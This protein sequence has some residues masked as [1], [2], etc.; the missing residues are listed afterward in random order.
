MNYKVIDGAAAENQKARNEL[1]AVSEMRGVYP[2]VFLMDPSTDTT[3]FIGTFETIESLI[4]DNDLP[5]AIVEE[6]NLLTFNSVFKDAMEGSA[7]APRKK[8]S[9]AAPKAED[10]AAAE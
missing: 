3:E 10:A 2:T 1:F 7:P 4:E 8:S 9:V 5:P 6:Q